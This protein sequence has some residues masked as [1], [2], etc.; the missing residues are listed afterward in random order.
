VFVSQV[1]SDGALKYILTN[2]KQ[3]MVLLVWCSLY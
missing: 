3:Q 1:V 2:L